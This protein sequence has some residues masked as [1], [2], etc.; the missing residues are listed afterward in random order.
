M[1]NKKSIEK[2]DGMYAMKSEF[3]KKRN[4]ALES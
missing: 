4:N 1:K 3:V 2:H